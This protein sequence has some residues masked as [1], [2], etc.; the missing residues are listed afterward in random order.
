M[1][2]NE[3]KNYEVESESKLENL[4]F[5]KITDA[6][7]R[8]F[9]ATHDGEG[10]TRIPKEFVDGASESIRRRFRNTAGARLRFNTN[11]PNFS[12]IVKLAAKTEWSFFYP[13][14]MSTFDVY[15]GKRHVSSVTC[16][17]E[18]TTYQFDKPTRNGGRATV[19]MDFPL[20]EDVVD[21]YIGLEDGSEIWEAEGYSIERPVVFYGSS[22]TQ[23]LS[24]SRPGMTYAAQLSREFDFDHINLGFFDGVDETDTMAN[25]I[26]G[27][28]MT[29]FVYDTD[30]TASP[31]KLEKIHEST[32]LKI[33][34]K[35]PDTPVVFVTAPYLALTDDVKAR[36]EIVKRTYENAVAR[37]DENV[38]FVSALDYFPEDLRLSDL[39]TDGEHFND[40]AYFFMKEAIKPILAKIL[41]K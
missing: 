35:Q 22:V 41:E 12:I 23:G 10:F 7:F 11:S 19:T 40:I 24:A 15:A 38:Y 5:L 31:E 6:P 32:F 3:C 34:E 17:E 29:A 2:V 8:I 18:K 21:V 16:D 33:R 9:G 27:L 37:G 28:D 26:S 20:A 13:M 1:K 30:V 39:T 14:A 4:R 25:Y 36:Y